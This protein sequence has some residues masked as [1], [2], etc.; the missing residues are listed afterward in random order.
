MNKGYQK[1]RKSVE[2][3]SAICGGL[4]MSLPVIPQSAIAEQLIAQ[5]NPC[6]RI[7]YEEPHNSQS[8]GSSR[9]ST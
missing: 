6:P 5:V 8:C 2:F 7:F 3:L 4:L 9:M 1:F